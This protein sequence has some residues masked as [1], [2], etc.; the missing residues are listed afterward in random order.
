MTWASDDGCRLREH[1]GGNTISHQLTPRQPKI[2]DFVLEVIMFTTAER[3][4]DAVMYPSRMPLLRTLLNESNLHM[5]I[6][7]IWWMKRRGTGD[8]DAPHH[9]SHFSVDLGF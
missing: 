4:G 6:N 2:T 5:H 8:V 7:Y 9:T 3:R 1:E